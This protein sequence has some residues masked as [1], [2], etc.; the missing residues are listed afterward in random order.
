MLFLHSVISFLYIYFIAFLFHFRGFQFLFIHRDSSFHISPQTKGFFKGFFFFSEQQFVYHV[1]ICPVCSMHPHTLM[2][3]YPNPS[4]FPSQ[5]L[6]LPLHVPYPSILSFPKPPH[7]PSPSNRL[8][9]WHNVT[10]PD[11]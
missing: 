11:A 1:H 3:M 6:F 7:W 9:I 2:H 8:I 4:S 10:P 5:S